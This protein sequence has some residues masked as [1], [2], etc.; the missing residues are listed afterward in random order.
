MIYT[1][2]EQRHLL[3]SLENAFKQIES[4]GKWTQCREGY[5][6]KYKRIEI[7][8]ID[9]VFIWEI[10]IDDITYKLRNNGIQEYKYEFTFNDN[11][12]MYTNFPHT[13]KPSVECIDNL[14]M[15]VLLYI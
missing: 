9:S 8:K 12:L 15:D 1:P 7:D 14:L 10:F 11:R 6:H 13:D 3:R 4:L 5:G 2:Q